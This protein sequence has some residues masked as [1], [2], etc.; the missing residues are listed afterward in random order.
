LLAGNKLVHLLVLLL[1]PKSYGLIHDLF[2]EFLVSD[3][4][5]FVYDVEAVFNLLAQVYSLSQHL[6]VRLK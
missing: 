3:A 6:F 4:F 1:L 5:V 2:L